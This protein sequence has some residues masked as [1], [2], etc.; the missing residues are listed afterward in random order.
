[1]T[2]V[3]RINKMFNLCHL[4]LSYSEK[5]LLGVN[6]ISESKTK[7]GSCTRHLTIV[8]LNES[9]EVE[10]DTLSSLRSKVAFKLPS[11]SDFACKHKVE[12]NSR[13]KVITGL[14]SLY[15]ILQDAFIQFCSIVIFTVLCYPVQFFP[16]FWLEILLLANNFGDSLI[17]ELVC[18][19]TLSILHIFNHKI[20][21]FINVTLYSNKNTFNFNDLSCII[22]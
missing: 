13:R 4:E 2:L 12:G 1:M 21:E 14:W 15:F 7:L 8:E 19:M 16:L 22:T 3:F 18:S 10:E 11:W 9:S 6:L 20:C 17:N 5:T